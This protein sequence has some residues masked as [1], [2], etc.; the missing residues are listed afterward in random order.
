MI[1]ILKGKAF[2]EMVQ[3]NEEGVITDGSREFK[4][5]LVPHPEHGSDYPVGYKAT[6][7]DGEEFYF[8]WSYIYK[9]ISEEV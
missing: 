2:R 8:T 5:E 3:N 1:N 9:M 7:N 4:F 6:R